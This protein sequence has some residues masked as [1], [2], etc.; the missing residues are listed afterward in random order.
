VD[1]QA[2]AGTAALRLQNTYTRSPIWDAPTDTLSADLRAARDL[3]DNPLPGPVHPADPIAA[4]AAAA[5]AAHARGRVVVPDEDLRWAADILVEVSSDPWAAGISSEASRYPMGADRSAA[6][7]L[8]ALLLPAFDQIRAAPG[9]LEEALRYAGTSPADEVRMIFARATAPVWTAPC[10]AAGTCRHQ[11]LWSAAIGGLADC[12]LGAW[13]P[14]SQRRLIEPLGEPFDETL[15]AVETERL[16][17]NRLTSPLIAA[18]EAARSESCVT[19]P[20]Q[21]VLG[22]LL[23]AHRRGAAYWAEKNYVNPGD[24]HGPAT[25]HVLAE[26]A[27]AG[28]AQPLTG[29]VRAYTRQSPR[30]LADLLH[31]LAIAFTYDDALRRALP[32]A[33]RPVMEAALEEIE[34]SPDLLTDRP[35]SGTA[36]AGLIAAPEPDLADPDPNATIERAQSAW[37]EPNY[38]GDLVERWL[39]IARGWP[40]AVDGLV[41]LARCGSAAWQTTTGLEWAEELIGGGFAAV[42]GRCYY[43]VRWLGDVRAALPGE[44][45]AARWRR[46]VDGLAAAG[47]NRAVRLQQAE[48]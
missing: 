40:E 38:F 29:H 43:L 7:A 16:L 39:P 30:A 37:S 25:A 11:V 24:Q 18:A 45:D 36:M 19:E 5:V 13:D 41:K 47:D 31:N 26:M 3:A 9:D 23:T 42:A 35:W 48:E 10:S 28:D 22:A 15:P 4:V 32:G 12:Q 17:V 20:A 1:G 21:A 34:A 14:A 6:A 27:A 46:V 33:W 8:P 44:A 2:E